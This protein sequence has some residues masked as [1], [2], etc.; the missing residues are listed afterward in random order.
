MSFF[1]LSLL[2]YSALTTTVAM[3]VSATTEEWGFA[4][5]HFVLAAAGNAL[6]LHVARRRS[7]AFLGSPA[8][9]FLV[10]NQV[11]FTINA[12]KYFSP[13]L[14]YPQFD[15]SLTAQ[16]WGSMAGGAVLIACMLVLRYRGAPTAQ[17]MQAWITRYRADLR[18]LLVVSVVVSVAC[19]LALVSL[20]YGSAYTETDYAA[21]GARIRSYEDFFLILG[22][23]LFGLFAQWLSIT[24]LAGSKRVTGAGKLLR[25]FSGLALLVELGYSVGYLKA[26]APLLL[27]AV[28]FAL[29]SELA[30]RRRAE[31]ILQTLLLLLPTVSLVGVQLTLLL[32][33]V[34]VPEDTGL[35]FAIAAIN[36][37]TDLTDFA[38]AIVVNSG[39]S[40]FDP[41]IVPAAVVNAVPRFL[42]IGAE[43]VVPDVYSEILGRLGWEAYADGVMLA[44]YQD[45]I[46]S[47]GVMA[48][49]VLGFMLL[50][51]ALTLLFEA[52]ARLAGPYASRPLFG[53][54]FIPLWLSAT[55]I[56][57][58]WATIV[59]NFRQAFTLSV[60]SLILVMVLRLLYH[61]LVI[62]CRSPV[63]GLPPAPNPVAG[64]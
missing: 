44:D 46:F 18:R 4:L 17:S 21:T 47:A 7:L 41:A 52:V 11:Y 39:G 61:I 45:S 6:L 13:I 25:L 42:F 2:V 20:G 23:E 49:G 29:T 19:K 34:N 1:L 32:G 63:E 36:R 9:A 8:L 15:L 54:V 51:I 62:A 30:S 14:L 64:S 35:R 10:M 28:L 59:L 60:V 37:R 58:E 26:R 22:S 40:A 3:R 24:F 5:G 16:F 27:A 31:R 56:E 43:K 12:L 48:G 55:H 50:P 57:V 53:L 38:T 33:R